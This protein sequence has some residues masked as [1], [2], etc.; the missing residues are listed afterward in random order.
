MAVGTCSFRG[1][2]EVFS[3]RQLSEAHPAQQ[4]G[5]YCKEVLAFPLEKEEA[6]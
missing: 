5:L 4:S 2:V 6:S 1:C 3:C